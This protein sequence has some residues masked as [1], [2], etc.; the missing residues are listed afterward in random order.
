[1]KRIDLTGKVFGNLTVIRFDRA[2]PQ[3]ALW[4]CRCSC[5]VSRSVR[6]SRLRSGRTHS[7]GRCSKIKHGLVH[8]PE[9]I[10]WKGMRQ[11]CNDPNHKNYKD[12]GGRGIKVCKRW[13]R[14]E[15]FYKDMGPRPSPKHS[16]DRENNLGHYT[17]RNCYWATVVEQ[18]NNRRKRRWYRRPK[19]EEDEE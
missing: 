4:Q 2:E 17:P 11:R 14:F 16:I 15:V 1:M 7:C 6:S 19:P 12:Y 3:G 5:G 18:N 9:Y 8:I 13:D 10:V